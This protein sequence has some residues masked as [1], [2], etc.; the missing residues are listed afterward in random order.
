MLSHI[1]ANNRKVLKKATTQET[2]PLRTCNCRNAESCPLDG[3]CLQNAV[4]YR[5]DIS[6]EE[7]VNKYY[8]GL[9]EQSFKG[10]WA[11]HNSSLRNIRYK[12]KSKLS[13]YVWNKRE[14]NTEPNIKWSI[15]KKCTPYRAGAKQCNLCL[16]EKFF[17][18]KGDQNMINQ[19]DE[20]LGKC[21]HR[22]KFLLSNY[23]NRK[24]KGMLP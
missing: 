8:V 9:T 1:K 4:V 2:T 12:T 7:G 13:T 5:A 10:R 21:R 16:W 14:E 15:L 24:R 23:K 3:N 18:V 19:K 11:D 22:D 17:I 20:L 6:P